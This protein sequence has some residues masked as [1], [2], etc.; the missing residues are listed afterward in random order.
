MCKVKTLQKINNKLK[1]TKLKP[2]TYFPKEFSW[3]GIENRYF[4]VNFFDVDQFDE[5]SIAKKSKHIPYE[6]SLNKEIDLLSKR[7]A[8]LEL[9]LYMDT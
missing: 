3:V 2:G 7:T 5:V 8:S 4:T 9:I 1:V 6:I